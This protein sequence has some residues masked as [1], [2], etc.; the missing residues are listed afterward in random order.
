MTET[1]K[2]PEDIGLKDQIER[3]LEEDIGDGDRTAEAV[4]PAHLDGAARI[5]AKADGVIAGLPIVDAVFRALEPAVT[6]E[7]VVPDATA[8]T[9]GTIVARLDGPYRALLTGE[10]VALNYLMH[11][12]GIAS[13]TAEF[14]KRIAGTHAQILDTRKTLPGYRRLEKYAVA[15]GGGTNHRMGLYDAILIKENHIAAVDGVEAAI[16]AA[17]RGAPELPVQVE[18]RDGVE[19]DAAISAGADSVLLDNMSPDE[20]RDHRDRVRG[21]GHTLP[22]EVSGG[23]NLETVEAYARAG[24]D[25]LSIG[26][27][28]H[29][30][31]ALDLS[32]LV[33]LRR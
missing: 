3:A 18:V 4:V 33:E 30:A 8:V 29:S 6:V 11:L 9:P 31:P 25:R 32:M 24:A 21:A 26:R 5:V 13:L 27:L 1:P 7:H 17:R 22:L 15:C 14:V 2:W 10:R 28:T 23:L 20:V 12:S 16:T 19:L